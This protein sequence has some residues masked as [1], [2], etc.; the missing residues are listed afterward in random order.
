[1][2][3]IA[4]P[5]VAPAL[6]DGPRPPQ[7]GRQDA[8]ALAEAEAYTLAELEAARQCAEAARRCEAA[9]GEA[10]RKRHA[11]LAAAVRVRE[12]AAKETIKA[13]R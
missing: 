12:S 6:L 1:M 11:A 2:V 4:G 7:C 3:P 8:C 13:A 9:G 5:P 10:A